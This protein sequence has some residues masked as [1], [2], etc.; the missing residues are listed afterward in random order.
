M[1]P[2]EGMG[3]ESSGSSESDAKADAKSDSYNQIITFKRPPAN[4][5]D[6]KEGDVASSST[7]PLRFRNLFSYPSRKFF[8][9]NVPKRL[10]SQTS[11]GTV[12]SY[13]S[14]SNYSDDL[15]SPRTPNL[16]VDL[17]TDEQNRPLLSTV[18]VNSDSSGNGTYSSGDSTFSSSMY[19]MNPNKSRTRENTNSGMSVLFLLF[20]PSIGQEIYIFCSNR[21]LPGARIVVEHKTKFRIFHRTGSDV[22]HGLVTTTRRHRLTNRTT[23]DQP[24]IYQITAIDATQH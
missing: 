18:R 22:C 17:L 15:S 20:S 24:E 10:N 5:T 3:A 19:K 2:D 7:R 23:I 4:V 11:T 8:N 9:K 21:R 14:S 6:L 13:L 16:P 12:S 1:S